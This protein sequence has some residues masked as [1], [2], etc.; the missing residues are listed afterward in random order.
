MGSLTTEGQPQMYGFVPESWE[1]VVAAQNDS[2]I[3]FL[4]PN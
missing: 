2:E 4:T 1:W 3:W